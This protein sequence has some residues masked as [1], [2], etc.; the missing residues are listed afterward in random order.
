MSNVLMFALVLLL[1]AVWLQAQQGDPGRDAWAVAYPPTISGCLANSGFHYTV[2][3]DKGRVYDLTGDTAKLR[4][5]I[6]HEVEITGAWRVRILDTTVD[7]AASSVEELAALDVKSV[8]E[9]STT[10]S[11]TN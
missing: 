5:Y 9:L 8:K 10:C 4:P 6:G 1:P 2:T 11:A 7:S 3:G